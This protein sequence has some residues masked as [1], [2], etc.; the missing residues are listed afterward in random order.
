MHRMRV[1]ATPIGYQKI[2]E[3]MGSFCGAHKIVG[4]RHPLTAARDDKVHNSLRQ[5]PQVLV[6]NGR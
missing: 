5:D 3:G 1:F 6:L 4:F 2:N